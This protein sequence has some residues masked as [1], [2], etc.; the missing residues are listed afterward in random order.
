M[1]ALQLIRNVKVFIKVSASVPHRMARLFG[2]SLPIA[3][4]YPDNQFPTNHLFAFYQRLAVVVPPKN[5]IKFRSFKKF[6]RWYIRKTFQPIPSDA[7]VSFE[8][9]LEKVDAN[10]FRKDQL[11]EAYLKLS[12]YGLRKQDHKVKTFVKVE[13]YPSYKFPRL[14]NSRSDVFKVFFGPYARLMEEIVYRDPHFIKHIPVPARPKY[15]KDYVSQSGAKYLITDYSKFE[16]HFTPMVMDAIEIEL[17]RYLLRNFRSVSDTAISVFLGTNHLWNN[18][19]HASIDACRMSGEV[20][21]SLGNGFSNLLLFLYV[22]YL[23]GHEDILSI[24]GVVEGDDGLFAL[25]ERIP[26]KQDFADLGFDI[27]LDIVDDVG[28]AA[29]CGL[30]FDTGSNQIIRD[31][32]RFLTKFNAF[33]SSGKNGSDKIMVSLLRAKVYSAICETP[34]CPVLWAFLRRLLRIT[35]GVKPLF[36]EKSWNYKNNVEPTFRALHISPNSTQAKFEALIHAP[37]LNT[38]KLFEAN[39]GVSIELQLRLESYFNKIN[40]T[41]KLC[42]DAISELLNEVNFD[43]LH[44]KTVFCY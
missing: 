31:P 11:R 43:L 15:L 25:H 12:T 38:R 26:T 39:Y 19:F 32:I 36:D 27:K 29:F 2:P 17:Y 3:A 41:T 21:T 30:I 28:K 10:Q 33:D 13:S 22:C 16:R 18:S 5:K 6:V 9:W 1:P 23:R 8:S 35:A 20:T 37:T 44:Y 24:R 40:L 7:D 42:G 14:I 34:S 4:P